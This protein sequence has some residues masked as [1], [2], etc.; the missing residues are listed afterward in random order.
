MFKEKVCYNRFVIKKEE[1]IKMSNFWKKKKIDT[2]KVA[3]ELG[4]EEKKVKE[5]KEGKRDIGGKTMEK[6]LKIVQQDNK[7]EDINILE[8]YNKSN[9][10]ELRLKF[11]Y[12]T[13]RQLADACNIERSSM[14][15]LERQ[16]KPKTRLTKN[17][18]RLYYFF[19]NDLNKLLESENEEKKTQNDNIIETEE[20]IIT[21][22]EDKNEIKQE[23]MC[24]TEQE[25]EIIKLREENAR[26]KKQIILYEKL[27]MRL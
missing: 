3:N 23:E 11:G 8:W 7:M 14:C 27:I 2:I 5:L 4:V 16:D 26:L 18:K 13:Q 20:D 19:S 12:K 6:V 21:E 15:L 1:K 9:I 17:I 10:K 24:N 22:Q 25:M